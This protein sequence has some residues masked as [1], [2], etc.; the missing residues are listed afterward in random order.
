MLSV[1][2]FP[3][4]NGLVFI[5]FALA[6][7]GQFLDTRTT[8]VALAT[9]LAEAN[10][11]GRF[12]INKLG[13]TPAYILKSA[14]LP[15]GF[16]WMGLLSAKASYISLIGLAIAGFVAAYLNYR[17]LSAPAKKDVL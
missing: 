14:V 5:L 16:V 12:L 10:P 7:F 6:S 15:I 2:D 8:E 13:I 11:I 1:E 17:R 4:N 9:G 3:M